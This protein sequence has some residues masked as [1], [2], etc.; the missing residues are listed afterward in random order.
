[1]V[2]DTF[3][4]DKRTSQGGHQPMNHHAIY[5]ETSAP[6][7]YAKDEDHLYVRLRVAKGEVSEVKVYYRDRYMHPPLYQIKTLKKTYE[8]G[9]FAYYDTTLALKRN[10]YAYYFKIQEEAGPSWIMDERGLWEKKPRVLRPYQYPYIAKEDVYQGAD[11]LK[12]AICYQIFPDRFHRGEGSDQVIQEEV[13]ASWGDKPTTKNH[14][15]GNIKGILDKIPYL[16]ELGITLLYF[17]PL[18]T[19]TTNH[20][21]NTKD[22]YEIDPSF[23]SLKE[24][25]ELV[26]RCHEAGIRVVFDAV[27]NHTG[28]D[29]FAF[30]DIL[31]KGEASA[32]KDWYHLDEFP[33]SLKKANYYTFANGVAH[34]PKVNLQNKDLRDYFLQVA[35]YW[36]KEVDID[37]YRLDVCDELSHDFLQ[38]LR[39]AVKEEKE[40]A[41]LIG[42]IMHE[43]ADFLNG[44]ELD[45]IMN[46]PFRHAMIDTF[47]R[48]ELSMEELFQVLLHNQVLYKEEITHQMLNL[49]GSHDVPRFLTESMGDK[50]KLKLATAFQFLYKGVPYIYYGDEVGLTG[51]KDPLCRKTMVWDKEHQDQ[52]LLA[53][54]KKFIA[55]RK[56]ETVL[57]YG[58]FT[59]HQVMDQA[60]AFTREIDGEKIHVFFN[61]QKKPVS[62]PMGQVLVAQDLW[63]GKHVMVKDAMVLEG[64]S[65]RVLKETKKKGVDRG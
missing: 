51:G 47:A 58:D 20:K 10:R 19:S 59:L 14:F 62:I 31:E 50:E 42:E 57:T 40:D 8:D 7:A 1:V 22:Y 15:G 54:F 6:Y 28:S 43:A 9:L 30:Q 38:D 36:I 18:F 25:K 26:R 35:K 12:E 16:Q 27:F 11:W 4:L 21:Y 2:Y 5:H 34:M 37:G 13:L 49:L 17:T 39:R 46:Y 61:L 29:F 52:D 24:T 55:L 53:F 44:Q 63:T 33:V 56:E 65:F 64:M 32:Y 48:E 60:F 45:S 3:F 41:V 23:G